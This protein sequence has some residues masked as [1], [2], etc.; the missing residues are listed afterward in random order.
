MSEKGQMTFNLDSKCID[1]KI[2]N[3][4]I[5]LND[6]HET[7][8]KSNLNLYDNNHIDI[9][10]LNDKILE[11]T[12]IDLN[13]N[14]NI[15]KNNL[16]VFDTNT[17]KNNANINHNLN[18]YNH[19]FINKGII[20][21]PSSYNN[22]HAGCIC[23]NENTNKINIIKNNKWSELFF[24]DQNNTGIINNINNN[25]NT[26]V[27]I[28]NNNVLTLKNNVNILNNCFFTY[29]THVINNTNIVNNLNLSNI[30]HINNIPIQYYRN[31]LRTYNSE[32]KKWYSLTIQ[33]FDLKYYNHYQSQNFYLHTITDT[34][35]YCN[36]VNNLD[37]NT[38]LINN[39]DLYYKEKFLHKVYLKHIFLNIIN[40]DNNPIICN[41][42][43]NDILY[44]TININTDLAC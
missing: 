36:T 44:H 20:E 24:I 19:I 35:K 28:K 33:K 34:L 7:N 21:L 41:L 2:N 18:T 5:R 15:Y 4:I 29:N 40:Y 27:K 32:L 31:L 37:Y 25:N 3:N 38:I 16:N 6:F 42:Y 22:Y 39:H 10:I 8:Y 9:N 23:Y 17:I 1:C 26:L 14:Y 12:N 43:K 30:I 11:S 13:L